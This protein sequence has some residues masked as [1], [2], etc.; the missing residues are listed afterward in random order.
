LAPYILLHRDKE[1]TMSDDRVVAFTQALVHCPSLPGQEDGVAA[2]VTQ[3]MQELGY[4]RVWVDGNG[5]AVGVLLGAMPGPTLLFD[6]HTDTVGIAPGVP[7]S[8]DPFGARIEGGALYGRGVV[9]MKGALAAMIHGAASVDRSRLAG[10]VVVSATVLEEHLEGAALRA[11]MDEV[12]P[13]FVVIGEPSNLRLVHGGRGRAEIRLETVGRPAHSSNPHLGRSAVLD[14]LR[15][16]T[17]M[18]RTPMPAHPLLGPAI[19]ALTDIISDPYPG[20]ST[21][22]SRCLATYDRRLLTGETAEEILDRIL[23]DPDLADIDLRA[24]IGVGEHRCYTGATLAGRKFLPAWLLPLDHPFVQAAMQGLIAAGLAPELDVYRFC[25]N[26]AYSAGA[27]GV[28]TV[29]FGPGHEGQAHMVDEHLEIAALLAARDG[30]R[31]IIRAA[32]G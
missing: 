26:A 28:P 30:Y 6:A 1:F 31:G 27:A 11:V 18:E 32:L 29:G 20:V 16:I 12:R 25:T 4:D 8:R 3:E 19:Q 15:V 9:D 13:D 2:L 14:M 24:E 10:Q 22:P 21:V 7:W 17:A 23:S 5:S